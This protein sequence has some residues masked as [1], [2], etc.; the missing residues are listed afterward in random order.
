MSQD[1]RE[2]LRV[3]R[4]GAQVV[5]FYGRVIRVLRRGGSGTRKV[6][7]TRHPLSSRRIEGESRGLPL[8]ALP[9]RAIHIRSCQYKLIVRPSSPQNPKILGSWLLRLLV[10][11]GASVPKGLRKRERILGPE[12]DSIGTLRTK[13]EQEIAQAHG[14]SQRV[15]TSVVGDAN[16]SPPLF[17]IPMGY[18]YA[19]AV[20]AGVGPTWPL[21]R[22]FEPVR[23]QKP[24]P[25]LHLLVSKPQQAQD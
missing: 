5:Q 9:G 14:R 22:V 25:Y 6:C 4:S 21:L 24:L 20:E 7:G 13:A 11:A 23:P 1:R 10:S 3:A 18:L 16:F 12:L 8:L 15:Q 2:R 19:E 17:W